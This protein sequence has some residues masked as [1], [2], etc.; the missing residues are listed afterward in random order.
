MRLLIIGPQGSGKGTQGGRLA[1][2]FKVP[3]ISTGELFR[4]HVRKRTEL[5][6][7]IQDRLAAGHLVDD[8]TT[9]AMIRERLAQADCASGFILEGF[10]RTLG[11]AHELDRFSPP[12][13]VVDIEVQ[14]GEAIERISGRRV[15]PS[16]GRAYHINFLPPRRPNQCDED[17]L[18]LTHREDDH[19]EAIA[20]RL[21]Q[22]HQ[23]AEPLKDY[24]RKQGKLRV[25]NGSQP[26][27]RV[28]KE[29]LFKL[30]T[31]LV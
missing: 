25:I 3:H 16:C 12:E 4:E 30:R 6:A 31:A 9:V 20:S 2:H 22:S 11:Q 28:F 13:A 8:A 15:C 5:G 10:P 7:R 29:I 1:E 21:A 26:I 14:D 19:P 18:A 17:G 23:E 24:Y 27:D